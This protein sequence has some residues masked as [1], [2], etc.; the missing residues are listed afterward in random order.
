LKVLNYG[1]GEGGNQ[2]NRSYEKCYKCDE[3]MRRGIFYRQ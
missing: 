1:A 2:L 3:P